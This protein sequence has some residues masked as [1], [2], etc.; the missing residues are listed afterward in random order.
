MSRR[1]H[2]FLF[3]TD[4]LASRP[5]LSL[6]HSSAGSTRRNEQVRRSPGE[7]EARAGALAKLEIRFGSK[8]SDSHRRFARK[9]VR[10]FRDLETLATAKEESGCFKFSPSLAELT[11]TCADARGE[12]GQR[13]ASGIEFQNENEENRL[14]SRPKL[15]FPSSATKMGGD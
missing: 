12:K 10:I 3:S 2:R 1:S 13:R 15:T 14:S 6:S 4:S 8:L 5:S 9:E 11:A 7:R